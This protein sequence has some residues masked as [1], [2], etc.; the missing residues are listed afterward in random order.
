MPSRR[1]DTPIATA[2]RGTH[3]SENARPFNLTPA[4]PVENVHDAPDEAHHKN[5]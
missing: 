5:H 3:A 4:R 2:F 1:G